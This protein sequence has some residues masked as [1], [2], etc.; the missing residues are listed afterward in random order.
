MFKLDIKDFFSGLWFYKHVCVW[1]FYSQLKVILRLRLKYK[2][3]KFSLI[4]FKTKEVWPLTS[5]A[6]NFSFGFLFLWFWFVFKEYNQL[7]QLFL[8]LEVPDLNLLIYFEWNLNKLQL[9]LT[10]DPSDVHHLPA[11]DCS[12]SWR[13]K[14]T[15]R[16][17]SKPNETSEPGVSSC[18]RHTGV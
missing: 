1:S 13:S 7:F 9:I 3:L 5:G 10:F 18:W 2:K 14:N 12:S 6:G 4:K 15:P 16:T 11:S 17:D 8:L